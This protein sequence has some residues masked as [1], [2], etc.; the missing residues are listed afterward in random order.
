[1]HV[2]KVS[3]WYSKCTMLEVE[4]C[5]IYAKEHNIYIKLLTKLCNTDIINAIGKRYYFIKEDYN[6]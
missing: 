1:M 2:E 4:D 6:L 5:V 3:F